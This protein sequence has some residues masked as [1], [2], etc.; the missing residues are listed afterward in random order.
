MLFEIPEFECTDASFMKERNNE[1]HR[2]L[3]VQL[4]MFP[5]K[6]SLIYGT[7]GE[8]GDNTDDLSSNSS[9]ISSLS[10]LSDSSSDSPYAAPVLR[11]TE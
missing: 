1:I 9:E 5:I 3:K 6:F 11:E 8:K 7:Q 10:S 2:E 4:F